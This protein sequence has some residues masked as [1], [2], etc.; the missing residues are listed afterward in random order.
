MDENLY[1]PMTLNDLITNIQKM[2]G[3][4]ELTGEEYV[5]GAEFIDENGYNYP[6]NTLML[7]LKCGSDNPDEP[8]YGTMVLTPAKSKWLM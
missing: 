7:E 6:P 3:E 1:I 4:Y 8:V 2:I 5:V